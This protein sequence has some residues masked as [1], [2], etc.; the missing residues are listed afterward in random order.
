MLGAIRDKDWWRDG[1]RTGVLVMEDGDDVEWKIA[2]R[3]AG[4]GCLLSD[5]RTVSQGERYPRTI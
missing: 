1:K 4:R 2:S 3:L 5:C